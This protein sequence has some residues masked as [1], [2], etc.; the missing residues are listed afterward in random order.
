MSGT[1]EQGGGAVKTCTDPAYV[2]LR[3][4]LWE[5]RHRV[6]TVNGTTW[7]PA[8]VSHPL[9]AQ[10]GALVDAEE[11]GPSLGGGVAFLGGG[12]PRGLLAALAVFARPLVH[13]ER[14]QWAAR[15]AFQ[16][17]QRECWP[18][19]G[20]ESDD[21]PVTYRDVLEV[22]VDAEAWQ[23]Y[24]TD[25]E[26]NRPPRRSM[27]AP[28]IHELTPAVGR[29]IT[30]LPQLR[31]ER[32]EGNRRQRRRVRVL[33]TGNHASYPAA[34]FALWRALL[35]DY[36]FELEDQSFDTRYCE[37]IGSC[38]AD[39]RFSWI[40][41][42]LRSTVVET[43]SGLFLKGF[44]NMAVLA[45]QFTQMLLEGGASSPASRADVLLC[46]HPPYSCRL[47]WPL[48][49]QHSKPLLGF[50]GGT[51]EAH[52][53]GV[54]LLAWLHDFR[55]MAQHPRVQFAAV[56]PFLAEKMRYQTGVD[57]P[58]ARGFGF[59]VMSLGVT[60]LPRRLHEV[61]IWKNSLEC[62]DNQDSLDELLMDL[63]WKVGSARAGGSDA[64]GGTPHLA[65]RHL[66]AL[67][68]AS[69]ASY[70]TIASFRAVL[71]V[72][73]EVLL[74]TFYELYHLAVPLFLPTLEIGCFLF[75][76]G[77][78]TFPHCPWTLGGDT[79]TEA[80]PL[81]SAASERQLAPYSPFKRDSVTDRLAWL[82]AY[83][84]WYRFPHIQRFSSFAELMTALY[85]TDL[86]AVSA[87]MRQETETALVGAAAFW[88]K[89]FLKVLHG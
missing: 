29:S 87:A 14:G 80:A 7:L 76:R 19:I 30:S 77:P 64:P 21:W 31:G 40:G 9:V 50:F 41:E 42:H 35:L 81:A 71:F 5:E 70:S 74:M 85:D 53:P 59:H 12:C 75:Y 78:V 89:A 15:V 38:T 68:A 11:E 22:A 47:F 63:S 57:I 84:D 34:M 60:Y 56:S 44:E 2:S 18:T 45:E 10:A 62:S 86:Q 33:S 55:V 72:P 26:Y 28:L 83:T 32:V 16:L 43:C 69:D 73:Y 8:R 66:R 67:R 49:Q 6:E 36:E 52:V 1:F 27:P 25:A 54:D 46:T 88:D 13:T 39:E 4:N 61:L 20:S 48:V 3:H 24:G 82:E 58:T 79:G 37:I 23:E 51:L 17:A 65:F